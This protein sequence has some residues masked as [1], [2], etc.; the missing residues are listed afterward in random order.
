MKLSNYRRILSSDYDE[1]YRTLVDN[2]GTT[3]NNSF[4]EVYEALNN[5]LTFKD[6]FLAT[7]ATVNVTVDS[8]G[9]PTSGTT[10]NLTGAQ[11][12]Y[13]GS[14]VL[15]AAGTSAGAAPPTGGVMLTGTRSN[16]TIT[17]TNVTGLPAN[18]QYALTIV[19][20]G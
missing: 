7:M 13:I 12:T 9:K 10:F 8:S 16:N 15:T 4:D 6:N 18:T 17:V 2:L 11:S 5:G 19:A 20:L 1:E 14:I 3:L